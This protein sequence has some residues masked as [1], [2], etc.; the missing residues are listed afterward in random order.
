MT[1]HVLERFIRCSF[2]FPRL[3]IDN[4]QARCF[5]FEFRL[6]H[7]L[8]S[9]IRGSNIGLAGCGMGLEIEARRGIQK[10]LEAGCGMK[11]STRDR[12]TQFF[13][14][15]MRDALKSMAG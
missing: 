11:S 5:L 3:L 1:A 4:K 12:D 2:T 7:L 6:F 10:K 15:G 13:T 14:V 9:Q 8:P